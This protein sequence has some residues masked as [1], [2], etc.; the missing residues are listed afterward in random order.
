MCA[1]WKQKKK[2]WPRLLWKCILWNYF[3]KRTK[4]KNKLLLKR[5]SPLESCIQFINERN[6]EV[7]GNSYSLFQLIFYNSNFQVSKSRRLYTVA[8]STW[9]LLYRPSSTTRW[10]HNQ[11][12][13]NFG[14]M[15]FWNCTLQLS[16]N[17][18][19]ILFKIYFKKLSQNFPNI[20][21]I[22]CYFLYV[23]LKLLL[24]YEELILWYLTEK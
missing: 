8:L 6:G 23:S 21:P 22:F 24:N 17:V 4:T 7:V 12:K 19:R 2:V 13:S 5:L 9:S 1:K 14:L 10:C 15:H 3:S 18:L 11:K 20:C 16:E